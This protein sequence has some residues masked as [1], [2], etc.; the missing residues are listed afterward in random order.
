MN[1]IHNDKNFKNVVI[2]LLS[3]LVLLNIFNNNSIDINVNN[4][5]C[6]SY[7]QLKEVEKDRVK[8]LKIIEKPLFIKEVKNEKL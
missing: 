7:E 1:Y 6:M 2:S 5:K 3:L 8:E 4:N